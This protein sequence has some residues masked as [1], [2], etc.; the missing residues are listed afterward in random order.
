MTH[1]LATL[2]AIAAIVAVLVIGSAILW[3]ANY[4]RTVRGEDREYREAFGDVP[5]MGRGP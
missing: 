3:A 5:W 2:L 1:V 4:V